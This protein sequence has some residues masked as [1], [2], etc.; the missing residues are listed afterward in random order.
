MKSVAEV[1]ETVPVV[2]T[3]AALTAV[4]L[5]N[6]KSFPFMFNSEPSA[7]VIPPPELFPRIKLLDA[8]DAEDDVQQVYSN[9]DISEEDAATYAG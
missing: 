3:N 2:I 7:K 6:W 1:V 9:E 8:L 4:P 5:N